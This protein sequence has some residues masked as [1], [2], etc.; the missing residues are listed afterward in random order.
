MTSIFVFVLLIPFVAFAGVIISRKWESSWRS[1]WIRFWCD[2][3]R[4]YLNQYDN[5]FFA[6]GVVEKKPTVV[7]LPRKFRNKP[8]PNGPES[9]SFDPMVHRGPTGFPDIQQRH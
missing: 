5:Y 2:R 1:K 6:T 3:A 8:K 7:R 4:G 9:L